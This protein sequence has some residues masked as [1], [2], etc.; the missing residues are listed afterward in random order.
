MTRSPWLEYLCLTAIR[1]NTLF[2][3]ND[4]ARY[5]NREGTTSVGRSQVRRTLD[6]LEANNEIV[7]VGDDSDAWKVAK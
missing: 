7:N 2:S 3:T 5:C 1:E 6:A 4:V